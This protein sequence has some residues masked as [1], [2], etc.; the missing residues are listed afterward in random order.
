MARA[1]DLKAQTATKRAQARQA[2]SAKSGGRQRARTKSS[3]TVQS[4]EDDAEVERKLQRKWHR[5]SSPI[6]ESNKSA[7]ARG[8]ESNGVTHTEEL[9][10]HGADGASCKQLASGATTTVTSS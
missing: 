4:D 3:A 8:D 2:L 5:V 9:G 1:D 7:G 10:G 6:A